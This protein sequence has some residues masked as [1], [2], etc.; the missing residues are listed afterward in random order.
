MI[1]ATWARLD[2][3]GVPCAVLGSFGVRAWCPGVLCV[4][5]VGAPCVFGV[6][7][8]G[9]GGAVLEVVGW[10]VCESSLGV[11]VFSRWRWLLLT[12]KGRSYNEDTR[13]NC[14]LTHFTVCLAFHLR[15]GSTHSVLRLCGSASDV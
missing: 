2:F 6:S 3:G 7:V 14:E 4:L 8:L 1:E 5:W 13:S 15:R 12:P 10:W 11:L 9:V